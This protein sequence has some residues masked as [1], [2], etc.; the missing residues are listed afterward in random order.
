MKKFLFF[1]STILW[2]GACQSDTS[3]TKPIFFDLKQYIA[4]QVRVLT[5]Q[6]TPVQKWVQ[7]NGTEQQVLVKD[8]DWQKEL[9]PFAQTDLN[10]PAYI[11][12]YYMDTLRSEMGQTFIYVLKETEKIPV[13]TMRVTLDKSQRIQSLT[14]EVR[15]ENFL[16]SSEKKLH[17]KAQPKGI[18]SYE[19]EGR[20]EMLWSKEKTFKILGILKP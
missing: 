20:Q 19:I 16:Y 8:I 3:L 13:K 14:I 9:E 1:C 6:K 7:V 10:K 2:V 11:Q 18:Q 15:N 4:Q 5:Q 12:S 17:L